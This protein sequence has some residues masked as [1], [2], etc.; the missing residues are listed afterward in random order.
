M[1]PIYLLLEPAVVAPRRTFSVY[2]VFNS[3]GAPGDAG[4]IYGFLGTL[5]VEESD[6]GTWVGRL[7]SSADMFDGRGPG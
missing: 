6:Y 4:D 7:G 1:S 2:R 3:S 5:N